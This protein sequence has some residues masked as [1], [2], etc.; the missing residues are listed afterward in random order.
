M[1]LCSSPGGRLA[2]IADLSFVVPAGRINQQQDDHL[3]LGHIIATALRERIAQA[4][5][6]KTRVV[7][8]F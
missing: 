3:I 8:A 1:G 5:V 7:A 6:A 2:A 4:N